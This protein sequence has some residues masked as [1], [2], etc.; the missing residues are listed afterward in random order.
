MESTGR[1]KHKSEGRSGKDVQQA[2]GK[3]IDTLRKAEQSASEYHHC[4][5]DEDWAEAQP[6]LVQQM[7]H[8][9]RDEEDKR[10]EAA[11]A[12]RVQR[13]C[14]TGQFGRAMRTLMQAKLAAINE[15]T[16]RVACEKF[17]A[18]PDD[19]IPPMPDVQA[20]YLHMEDA[21]LIALVKKVANGASPASDGWTGELL[22]HAVLGSERIRDFIK[23]I[24]M[25]ALNDELTLLE[26]EVLTSQRLMLIDK[27]Q[28]DKINVRPIGISNPILKLVERI[29]MEMTP[30]TAIQEA[31][32][33]IQLG[34]G[35]NGGC[36]AALARIQELVRMGKESG[37]PYL[38]IARDSRNAFNSMARYPIAEKL[39]KHKGLAPLWALF[40]L[41]YT[42]LPPKMCLYDHETGQLAAIIEM[43]G[44]I[45]QGTASGSLFYCLGQ[46]DTLEQAE[47]EHIT[48][49]LLAI[50]DDVFTFGPPADAIN[51]YQHVSARMQSRCGVATNHDKAQVMWCSDQPID[52]AVVE[53]CRSAGLPEP[54]PELEALGILVARMASKQQQHLLAM[55]DS[56]DEV[57][58]QIQQVDIS[59]QSKVQLLA[60]CCATK[61][62]YVAR[63]VAPSIGEAAYEKSDATIVKAIC[64]LMEATPSEQADPNLHRQILL[65]LRHGGIGIRPMLNHVGSAAWWSALA[66]SAKHIQADRQ[67]YDTLHCK[68]TSDEIKRVWSD[69]RKA[70]VSCDRLFPDLSQEDRA[71]VAFIN[72]YVNV[73]YRKG[74]KLQKHLTS[75]LDK[76]RRAAL[77][78]ELK[79]DTQKLAHLDSLQVSTC[80]LP[81]VVLPK[82]SEHR[83]PDS[84]FKMFLRQRFLL[85]PTPHGPLQCS[86]GKKFSRDE[87]RRLHLI[88]CNKQ[89]AGWSASHDEVVMDLRAACKRA[90]I[91]ATVSRVGEYKTEHHAVPDI[92]FIDGAG[93]LVLVDVT[94][95]T[96]DVK[97]YQG[98]SRSS[99]PIAL[100]AQEKE[101]LKIRHH[102]G[103]AADKRAV[104]YPFGIERNT[105]AFGPG[106]LNLVHHIA[107]TSLAIGRKSISPFLLKSALAI[108]VC[109]ANA[110][111]YHLAHSKVH[112]KDFQDRMCVKFGASSPSFSSEL[113]AVSGGARV[114]YNSR[115]GRACGA[116]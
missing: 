110:A 57:I 85:P 68:A 115:R 106:A 4:I 95:T 35:R 89:A 88:R 33:R 45:I 49:T 43:L 19:G 38:L 13:L 90:R 101:R 36:E 81:I 41:L 116:G 20:H 94:L 109:R 92:E 111:F 15:E 75:Q 10:R 44:G 40:K 61:L 11:K 76:H 9:E 86:C 47:A 63:C 12:R 65:P 87:D 51:A 99:E 69:L 108:S 1:D 58:Q 80:H 72:F 24:A 100:S 25:S 21:K 56:I 39:Y 17:P 66:A 104:F 54:K 26:T 71:D 3:Q 52:A 27:S 6:E 2:I 96:S 50:I 29:A 5:Q 97:H 55:T 37:K 62:G 105:L 73:E 59:T 8:A 82:R 93:K 46:Q 34:I 107:Q 77:E 103:M 23:K 64:H 28:V 14:N 31:L 16:I 113:R 74:D 67:R 78:Q 83:I 22:A 32:P 30:Q 18:Y 53:M 7:S 102:E 48:C 42:K 60:H 70:G 98:K 79:D 114:S 84:A 112:D 91:H